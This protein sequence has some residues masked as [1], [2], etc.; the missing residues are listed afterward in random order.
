MKESRPLPAQ[1]VKN[2]IVLRFCQ[3]AE[4]SIKA[5]LPPSGR[6]LGRWEGMLTNANWP[7]VSPGSDPPQA[8][9]T[10][11]VVSAARTH[12]GW[13]LEVLTGLGALGK[14]PALLIRV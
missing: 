2:H 1:L 3:A 9:S 5:S 10:Y 7:S 13:D 11:I 6:L 8:L 14:L 12:H 4:P